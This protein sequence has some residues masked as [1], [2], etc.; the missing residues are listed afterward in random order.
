M[1]R[2][3]DPP[4]S[5]LGSV[6]PTSSGGFSMFNVLYMQHSVDSATAGPLVGAR[7]ARIAAMVVGTAPVFNKL[8]IF[9][10]MIY[11]P[12]ILLL[13]ALGNGEG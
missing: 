3:G 7:A 12:F 13:I 4:R 8:E 6:C 11:T 10:L 5:T 1:N 9:L 2:Q